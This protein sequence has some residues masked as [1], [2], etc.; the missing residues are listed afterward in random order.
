MTCRRICRE[1]LIAARFGELGPGSTPHL[2]HLS[3]CRGCRDEL[4][5]DRAL[6]RQLRTALAARVEGAAPS[7]Q[8][9]EGILARM[10]QPEPRPTRLRAWST[11]VVARLRF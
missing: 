1:L 4:G 3:T 6:V 5:F 9:W 2:E 8:A 10:A 11:A 7:P